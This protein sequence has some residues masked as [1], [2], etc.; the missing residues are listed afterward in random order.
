MKKYKWS[1]CGFKADANLVGQELESIGTDFKAEDVVNYATNENTELHKCF[2]WDDK[3][4]GEK[5]R[6]VQA[7]SIICSISIVTDEKELDST[8][9]YVNIKTGD[10]GRKFKNIAEVIDND[11]EYQQLIN[12]AKEE[13]ENCKE[14]YEKILKLKDLKEILFDLYKEI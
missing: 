6:L 2:E 5:Y 8:R 14:K 1:S 13:F 12:K 9:A 11:D 3:I 7:N 4:A 10:S